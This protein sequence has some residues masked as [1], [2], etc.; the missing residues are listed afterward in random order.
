[1]DSKSAVRAELAAA[2]E[3][4]IREYL[5]ST[6]GANALGAGARVERV[7]PSMFK[8]VADNGTEFAVLVGE[9]VRP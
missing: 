1:M 8:V 5:N 4:G 3:A 7:L 2:A 6:R 9:G